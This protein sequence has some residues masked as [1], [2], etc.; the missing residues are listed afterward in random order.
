MQLIEKIANNYTRIENLNLGVSKVTTSQFFGIDIQPIAIELSKMTM[1]L[2]KE[3]AVDDWNNRISPLLST[4]GFTYDQ[5]LPLENLDGNLLCQDALLVDWPEFDAVIGN[6]PYQSKNKMKQEMDNAY[7]ERVR[8]RYPDVPGRADFCVYWFRKAHETMKPRQRAGLVGTNTIR[9]N[10]SREGGLDYIIHNGGTITDAI[11]TQVWSGDAAVHVSIVNWVKGN[12]E[13]EKTL[14]FQNGN[15]IDSPYE[16]FH[17]TVIPSSLSI[18]T[19]VTQAKTLQ[20]CRNSECCK[21]GQTHGHEGFLL[22]REMAEKLLEREPRYAEVL[23]PFL[24]GDELLGERDSLP[25]RYVIDFR[26][27]DVFEASKYPELFS[28]IQTRVY[29][30][31][32]GKAEA[33]DKKNIETLQTNPRAKINHHHAAFLKSWWQLSWK[34]D[35]LMDIL[36]NLPRYI[37]CSRVTKRPIFEFISSKIHPNDALQVFPLVDDYSFGILQSSIHWE[38]FKARCSTLEERPRYTSDTVF[39]SFPWPQHPSVENVEAISACGVEL[40]LKRREIMKRDSISLRDIYRLIET[41]PQNPIS[42]LQAK[43][44]REVKRAYGMTVKSNVLLHLLELNESLYSKEQKG[45]AI[46]APGLPSFLT[47][48]AKFISNDSVQM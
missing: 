1:M 9:Q 47:D 29:P 37:V 3:L 14:I 10:Y 32:K 26:K 38:W 23:F 48:K 39:D 7:I 22:H 46:E 24:I 13:R 44:D 36:E 4:L 31:K 40:R 15:S 8:A 16:Y 41:T 30:E 5:A 43:L 11:S 2:A 20:A 12:D 28:I 25:T 45:K 6:P 27:Q 17:P 33:E 42:G 21:Q 34:R 35:E 18:S 19:D